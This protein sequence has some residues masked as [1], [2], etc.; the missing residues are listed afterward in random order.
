MFL[1]PRRKKVGVKEERN[2]EKGKVDKKRKKKR[3]WE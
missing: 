3:E 2:T 1:V